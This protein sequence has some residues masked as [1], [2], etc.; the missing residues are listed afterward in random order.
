MV[1]LES[2][3]YPS[4]VRNRSGKPMGAFLRNIGKHIW[5]LSGKFLRKFWGKLLKTGSGAVCELLFRL[6]KTRMGDSLKDLTNLQ[7][8]FNAF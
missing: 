2:R 3:V 1:G 8:I 4:L 7:T 6:V 5:E